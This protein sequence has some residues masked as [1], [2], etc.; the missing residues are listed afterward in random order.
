MLGLSDRWA[1]F[2]DGARRWIASQEDARASVCR[3]KAGRFT[4]KVARTLAAATK[5]GAGATIQ[6]AAIHLDEAE[7]DVMGRTLAGAVGVE[8]M[9]AGDSPDIDRP[10]ASLDTT[11]LQRLSDAKSS[12]LHSTPPNSRVDIGRSA[13]G[14]AAGSFGQCNL[15][16][17]QVIVGR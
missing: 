5:K 14:G 1:A 6:D 4:R 13:V 15:R 17:D 10:V 12:A 2:F 16:H 9:L 7:A 3:V 11:Q 8:E